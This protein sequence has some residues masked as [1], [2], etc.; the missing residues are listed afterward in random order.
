MK[1]LALD[2]A[3]FRH[4]V[5]KLLIV[6]LL[7][8][9]LLCLFFFIFNLSTLMIVQV[10]SLALCLLALLL[11]RLS[12]FKTI[13]LCIWLDLIGQAI[14]TSHELGWQSGFHFYLWLFIPIVACYGS[15]SWFKRAFFI[16]AIIVSYLLL[17]YR[18]SSQL[19]TTELIPHFVIISLR[20]FNII[21]S[22]AL[23]AYLL[24][25]YISCVEENW[26]LTTDAHETDQLTGLHNRE[27][28]LSKIDDLF[29]SSFS[30]Q[31]MS[32]IIADIDFFKVMNEQYG[33]EVGDA[34]LIYVAQ[35]LHDS[36]RLHDRASRW[37]GGEF[38]LLLPSGSAQSA[39]QIAE[40]VKLKLCHS[41]LLFKGHEVAISLTFGIA[42]LLPNEDFN[43]CLMRADIALRNGKTRG[44]NRIELAVIES[45]STTSN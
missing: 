31:P 37:G 29:A 3:L 36:I 45:S 21:V 24:R 41:P 27:A 23:L 35:I 1:A 32:L 6:A 4:F 15:L 20:Y 44:R 12:A 40:R 18:F 14:A 17:D 34:A 38:L 28:M 16:A 10:A 7:I 33:H 5:N 25:I 30:R 39:E 11:C 8:H 26:K 2:P 43:Q 22:V 42:E 13:G 19:I 9:S